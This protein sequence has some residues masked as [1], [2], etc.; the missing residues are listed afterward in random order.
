[1]INTEFCNQSFEPTAFRK[2]YIRG[3]RSE[4]HR[5][6]IG[7]RSARNV[8]D[9]EHSPIGRVQVGTDCSNLDGKGAGVA[10]DNELLLP[11]DVIM[12]RVHYPVLCDLNVVPAIK[13]YVSKHGNRFTYSDLVTFMNLSDW[14]CHQL[15]AVISD[16]YEKQVIALEFN[17]TNFAVYNLI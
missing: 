12:G 10:T 1:M 2:R 14:N 17:T 5:F 4:P 13:D 3:E 9:A 7:R 16:L 11:V 15:M 6:C 8:T